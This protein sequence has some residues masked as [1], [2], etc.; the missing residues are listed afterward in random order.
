MAE[1]LR[2]SK[3]FISIYQMIK[4]ILPTLSTQ[5]RTVYILK[6]CYKQLA[7]T[8]PLVDYGRFLGCATF[9]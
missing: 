3:R 2:I 1:K 6:S 5:V 9:Y 4:E 8:K 7:L